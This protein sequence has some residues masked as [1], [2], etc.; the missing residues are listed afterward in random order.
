MYKP[1]HVSVT[2]ITSANS[3]DKSCKKEENE[4]GQVQWQRSQIV[5]VQLQTETS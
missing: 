5:L 2:Q 1:F 3:K 4:K